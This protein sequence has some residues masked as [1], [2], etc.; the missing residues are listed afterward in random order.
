MGTAIT[1]MLDVRGQCIDSHGVV[2]WYVS[3]EYWTLCER[4][5]GKTI[6]QTE[7]LGF[8]DTSDLVTCLACLAT[9]DR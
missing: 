8:A 3:P 6:F 7:R 2:H 9:A 5:N 4:L 1:H